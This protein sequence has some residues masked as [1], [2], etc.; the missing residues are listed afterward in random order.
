MAR[1]LTRRQRERQRLAATSGKYPV[2]ERQLRESASELS[3]PQLPP[4]ASLP[5]NPNYVAVKQT[6]E[7]Y[8][9]AILV[10]SVLHNAQARRGLTSDNASD[11]ELPGLVTEAMIGL[12]LFVAADKLPE[13]MLELADILESIK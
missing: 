13:L 4:Q 1:S 11:A 2:G 3:H 8:I 6:L 12:R 10:S 9:S 5:V 7:Q